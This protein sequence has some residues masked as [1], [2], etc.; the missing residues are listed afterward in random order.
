MSKDFQEQFSN[1]K[2]CKTGKEANEKIP[3]ASA[4]RNSRLNPPRK[5]L[6]VSQNG[7]LTITGVA[8]SSVGWGWVG[9]EPRHSWRESKIIVENP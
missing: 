8:T 1:S 3:A 6:L 5:P 7:R 4:V 2:N 9:T